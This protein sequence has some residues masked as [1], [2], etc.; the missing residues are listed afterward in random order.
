MLEARVHML[1][2]AK[3]G[4]IL[5]NDIED[6]FQDSAYDSMTADATDA[7]PPPEPHQKARK[8]KAKNVMMKPSQQEV[9]EHMLTHIPCRSWCEQ[10]VAGKAKSNPHVKQKGKEE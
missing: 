1:N 9:D 7:A 2:E 4:M 5:S 3:P 10:C 8:A 6:M